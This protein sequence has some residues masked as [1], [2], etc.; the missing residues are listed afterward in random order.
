MN[1]PPRETLLAF[2]TARLESSPPEEVDIWRE[3]YVMAQ[4]QPLE[5]EEILITPTDELLEGSRRWKGVTA[6]GIEVD[7]LVRV[8]RVHVSQANRF[9]EQM[10][11]KLEEVPETH[12]AVPDELREILSA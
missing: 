5:A 8:I 1:R 9:M 12:P 2:V 7:V 3:L 4:T 11:G 10:N 6:S